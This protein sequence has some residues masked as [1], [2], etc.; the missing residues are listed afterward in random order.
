MDVLP[1]LKD[2]AST[3]VFPS[4]IEGSGSTWVGLVAWASSP[5]RPTP[6]HPRRE[7]RGLPAFFG[8]GEQV[9]WLKRFYHGWPASS[10]P[11]RSSPGHPHSA[12][13]SLSH[14]DCWDRKNAFSYTIKLLSWMRSR[15]HPLAYPTNYKQDSRDNCYLFPI[16]KTAPTCP[17]M[18][19]KKAQ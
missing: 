8:E 1:A 18:T 6:I 14:G 13:L 3:A 2:G 12:H 4:P 10:T 16:C 19:R 5:A 7:R 11:H 17:E 15:G 9:V